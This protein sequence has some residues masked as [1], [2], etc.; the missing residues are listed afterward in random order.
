MQREAIEAVLSARDTL[1]VM[2]TGGGNSLCYQLPA[3]LLPGITL[4]IS[5]L[6]ALMQDQMAKLRALGIPALAL[7]S[8]QSFSESRAHVRR[9]SSGEIKLLFVAPERLE[10]SLFREELSGLPI[11]LLAI[12]EAHCISQWG[13]DFRTS[14]RRIPDI[15]PTLNDG[16]RP[17]IVALTAT[18]TPEVR[19]DIIRLL[20]LEQP[21]EIV[22]GF[23]RPNIAYGVLRES[24]KDIRVRDILSSQNS[25]SAIVYAA[26]RRSV[27]RISNDLQRHGFSASAY[28][29]GLPSAVRKQAQERF[30][31]SE[32]AII[33]ATSAFGMGIDKPDVR[34]V[35]HYDIPASL[36]AYY[37]ESGR[38][39]RDGLPSH[40][41]LLY[42]QNDRSLQEMLLRSNSPSEQELKWAYSA[43]HE[44]AGTP[45]GSIHSGILSISK[46]QLLERFPSAE[47][48]A[49]TESILES[50]ERSGHLQWHRN[51]FDGNRARI[52]FTATRQRF[53]EVSFKTSSKGVKKTIFALL[54]ALGSAGAF[55]NEVSLDVGHLLERHDIVGD[56]FTSAIATIEGLGLV[57]YT[58]ATRTKNREVYYLSFVSERVPLQHLQLNV[59]EI[60]ERYKSHLGKLDAMVSYAE[61]WQC[62]QRT[63]LHYFGEEWNDKRCGACDVCISLARKNDYSVTSLSTR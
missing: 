13:H 28:H 38:A 43:L 39:G 23:E 48:H 42:N 34:A 21:V 46:S 62:R 59:Q 58:P 60:S 44:I 6:I 40:A 19:S 11:S 61:K 12:D 15:F 51:Y 20:Q 35:V 49:S 55:E 29:A 57:R 41:I 9:M 24:N 18:A 50:L 22:T 31:H 26:T 2:P 10:S 17:P 1:V 54:R 5:P 14:Y 25:G 8:T 3:L 53:D 47:K 63:I 36:E 4:V 56:E 27:D 16:R 45:F 37:Q 7:N 30:Q 32:I 33:V 52:Q